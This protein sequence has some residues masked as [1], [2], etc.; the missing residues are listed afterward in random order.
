AVSRLHAGVESG[1]GP[2]TCRHQKP[3]RLRTD[4]P[5]VWKR[6]AVFGYRESADGR[7]N[8]LGTV[9]I[10]RT[11]RTVRTVAADETSAHNS[12]ARRAMSD[13]RYFAVIWSA[14]NSLEATLLAGYRRNGKLFS[15]RPCP[16]IGF[17]VDYYENETTK[18]K[19]ELGRAVIGDFATRQE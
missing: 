18:F 2:G 5:L 10:V 15:R 7:S 3:T 11:L 17:V 9:R 4:R 14:K 19:R 1:S 12:E 13:K 6:R 8:T 16:Y